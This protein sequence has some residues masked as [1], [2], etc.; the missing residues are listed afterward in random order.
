MTQTSFTTPTETE[1]V[2]ERG[3]RNVLPVKLTDAEV[4]E[5]SRRR[6]AVE[7]ERDEMAADL[8][9]ETEKRKTALEER[10]KEILRLRRWIHTGEQERS[11]PCT[12]VFRRVIGANGDAEGWVVTIRNDTLAEVTREPATPRQLQRYLPGSEL[13]P[14]AA[15][16]DGDEPRNLLDQATAAQAAE[17]RRLSSNRPVPSSGEQ[18]DDDDDDGADAPASP[19]FEPPDDDDNN[20][21]ETEGGSTSRANDSQSGTGA[22]KLGDRVTWTSQASGRETRKTGEVVAVIPAGKKPGEI[23]ERMNTKRF[24]GAARDHESYGVEVDGEIYWPVVAKLKAAPVRS[25][26]GEHRAP[27]HRPLPPNR[28]DRGRARR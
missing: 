7:Q 4:L 13:D 15:P 16:D 26:G 5:L 3:L 25:K 18:R 11:V 28:L 27:E 12:K 19:N 24:D 6:T 21:N 2:I 10:D 1:D 22:F 20:N 8:K 23:F 17:E 14:A 9:S